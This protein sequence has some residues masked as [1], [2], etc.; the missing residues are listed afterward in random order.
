MLN[1]TQLATIP[2]DRWGCLRMD[3]SWPQITNQ[4][5]YKP[6]FLK[7]NPP[8]RVL[9]HRENQIL[10]NDWEDVF[11]FKLKSQLPCCIHSLYSGTTT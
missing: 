2:T 5:K 8:R 3:I 1:F 6:S 10:S 7:T 4:H 9:A 11:L